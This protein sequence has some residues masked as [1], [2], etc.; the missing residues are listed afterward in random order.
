MT[1]AIQIKVTSKYLGKQDQDKSPQMYVFSYTVNI[2]N[3]SKENVKLLSRYWLITNGDGE[4]V[5]VEGDGVIGEQPVIAP[6]QTYSYTSA[7]ML[8]TAVGTMQG[9]Y[10]FQAHNQDNFKTP[11]PV[12]SLAVPNSLH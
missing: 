12:F 5:E 8:K 10:K 2:T 11:I 3:T 7:S 4:K 9:F 6:N 1:P